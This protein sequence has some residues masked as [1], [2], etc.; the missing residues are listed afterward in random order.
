[1]NPYR[2]PAMRRSRRRA[3]DQTD[4]VDPWRVALVVAWLLDLW[5]MIASV[6]AHITPW[7]EI[8]V[9]VLLLVLTALTLFWPETRQ[10]PPPPDE[11][12]DP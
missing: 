3:G 7:P 10:D 2:R 4:P 5:R 9:A 11:E 8:A 6:Q 12:R 1:M